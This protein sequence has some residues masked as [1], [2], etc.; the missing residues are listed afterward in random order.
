MPL[1]TD[2][3]VNPYFD[4]WQSN[5][6][7]YKVLFKPGV[8]VQARELN[9]FQTI[10]QDQIEQFGDNI[11]QRGT[12]IAGCN[13]IFYPN[14]PY[15]KLLDNDIS[16]TPIN[17]GQFTG[18]NLVDS[19]NLVATV[20]Q[21]IAGFESTDPDLNTLYIKY[22]NS[23]SSQ[24]ETSYS[25]SEIITAYDGNFVVEGINIINGS[26]GFSNSDFVVISSA[27]AITNTTGGLT[28]S[29]GT[30]GSNVFNVGDTINYIGVANVRATIIEVNS[31]A[32]S[33]ALILKVI[34]VLAD[35]EVINTS[36]LNWTFPSNTVHEVNTN[37]FFTV[38][39]S[40]GSGASATLLT[41]GFGNV[42][43]MNVTSGGAGYY[44]APQV[45]IQSNT[46][47]IPNANLIARN[48]LTK[49]QI[50]STT[51]AVGNGYAFGVT[52]G[53][54]Y[55][56]GYFSR[57]SASVIVVDKYDTTPDQVVVG[58]DTQELIINSNIDQSLL[59]NAQGT[60]NFTAPGADRLELSP[61]LVVETAANAAA[62]ALFFPIVEW[63]GGQ[64]FKQN[65]TTQFNSIETELAQRTYDTAGD[66]T[67]DPFLITTKSITPLA[68][69]ANNANGTSNYDIFVDAGDAYVQ[70]F[71]IDAETTFSVMATKG[72]NTQNINPNMT[73]V[74]Y[75]SYVLVDNLGGTFSFQT[76]SLVY[77]Y[78]SPVNYTTN[79]AAIGTV[80]VANGALIGTARIRS[81]L[82]D[83]RSGAGGLP[84]TPNATYRFYLYDIA[85]ANGQS[86]TSVQSIYANNSGIFTGIADVAVAGLQQPSNNSIIIPTGVT[87][88]QTIANVSYTYRECLTE[89]A[90][91]T[92]FISFSS[93]AGEAFFTGPSVFFDTLVVPQANILFSVATGNVTIASGNVNVTGVSTTFLT[94]FVAG[95]YF[96]VTDGSSINVRRVA[97]ITNNTFMQADSPFAFSNSG[98]NVAIILPESVPV[99]L[100]RTGRSITFNGS[101]DV[102]T[103]NLANSWSSSTNVSVTFSAV[104]LNA[105]PIV[106]TVN[107]G[108]FVLLNLSNNVGDI[109]GPWNL[110]IPDIIR[111][112]AVYRGSSTSNT[113][114]TSNFYINGGQNENFVDAGSL[115]IVQG[116]SLAL[117]NTDI[118]LVKF[119]C[120]TRNV[121]G[122]SVIGSYP[123]NDS[124][125]LASASATLN[126]LEIPELYGNQGDYYDLRDMLDFR[127][128]VTNSAVLATSNSTATVN[129]VFSNA[130]VKFGNTS[131][132]ANNK[133]IPHPISTANMNATYYVGR[134]DKVV[135]NGNGTVTIISG[136]P[137]ISTKLLPPADVGNSLTL[138]TI[139]VPPYPTIPQLLS[140]DWTLYSDTTIVNGKYAGTRK[141]NFT[142]ALPS[143]DVGVVSLQPHGY[144]MK[145]IG[146]LET[147]IQNLEAVLLIQMLNNS[148]QDQG[149][150]VY[151]FIADDFSTTAYTDEFDP[152]F[153]ASI[154][155]GE[156]VPRAVEFALPYIFSS[157]NT[158]LTLPY[159]SYSL[160]QQ[161]NATVPPV[162]V[163]PITPT[164]N[165]PHIPVTYNGTMKVTPTTYKIKGV[166]KK[167]DNEKTSKNRHTTGGRITNTN[168][169]STPPSS[170]S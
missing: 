111:L 162:V 49:F 93:A 145:Q 86:F 94:T 18:L 9:Q 16:G 64:P 23:G 8:A 66:F 60:P 32:N 79:S 125:N 69:E 45:T 121:D 89:S 40:I 31:T 38:V 82:F 17:L 124:V 116:S 33:E 131:D 141:N 92:G 52:D 74:N 67:L 13:F 83:N 98:A 160:V 70:G 12:V 37:T 81:I 147:R 90:N 133:K 78:N 113:D 58:F 120:L 19:S 59:D 91:T 47:N 3:N 159:Q 101:S 34:P 154:I 117:T 41:D 138:N 134:I 30:S 35:L 48:Y 46:G 144:T 73:A 112:D 137:D 88:A 2:F 163:V 20:L 123:V 7:F 135:V 57:V 53:V 56:K 96:E 54:I 127:P 42:V 155:N 39:D 157:G 106:K 108:V 109:A 110:G 97:S 95:D 55:Q 132:P 1:N 102:V 122:L 152:E 99:S 26:L 161:L 143:S 44:V 105:T 14:Y 136:K 158:Y 115:A 61:I 51:N 4:D 126:T 25:P 72:V 50:S 166:F 85:M 118:L 29:N 170:L 130:A 84:G 5:K 43:I 156:L 139:I 164:P 104:I 119:D 21:G 128:A 28:F 62:N 165:T 142:I 36:P 140:Q 80:P 76:A 68:L 169:S 75:G 24:N 71:K 151:G 168:S 15:I 65:R 22:L 146:D 103:I 167:N 150:T 129:P 10:L 11:F 148:V 107:R 27:L 87:A 63:S 149:S 6:D 100:T 77:L 114:I 153:N